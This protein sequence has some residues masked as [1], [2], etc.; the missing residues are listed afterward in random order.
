[1]APVMTTTLPCMAISQV[2]LSPPTPSL[3]GDATG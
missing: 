3:A 2:S 1:V